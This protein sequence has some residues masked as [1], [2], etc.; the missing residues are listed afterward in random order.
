MALYMHQPLEFKNGFTFI[1]MLFVMLAISLF[2]VLFLP[3]MMKSIENQRTKHFLEV[4]YSDILMIQNQSLG[5]TRNVQIIFQ[6]DR[7]IIVYD[8]KLVE[9]R[10]YPEHLNYVE[11]SYNVISFNKHG[12][13]S[14]LR[15]YKFKDRSTTYQIVFPLGKGRHYIEEL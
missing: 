1:E 3:N 14:H 5:K 10:T 7:Y 6:K 2:L 12:A 15:K 4:L 9:Y 11:R 13:V 8:Q